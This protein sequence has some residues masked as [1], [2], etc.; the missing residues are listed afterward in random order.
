MMMT[1]LKKSPQI[2]QILSPCEEKDFQSYM[3][4]ESKLLDHKVCD[5]GKRTSEIFRS[6]Q[7]DTFLQNERQKNEMS[8]DEAIPTKD[9]STQT[10]PIL[11]DFDHHQNY[12]AFDE[13]NLAYLKRHKPCSLTIS[14]PYELLIPKLSFKTEKTLSILTQDI[15][16]LIWKKYQQRQ[17]KVSYDL[18]DYFPGSIY[19]KR[20]TH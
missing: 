20:H 7:I 10:K 12:I 16:D 17:M 8:R 15:I 2:Y 14:T 6:Q 18:Q 19:W 9:A 3:I 5:Y 11:D 4:N 13:T 1:I